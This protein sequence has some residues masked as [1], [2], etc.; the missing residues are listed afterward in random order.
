M[1]LTRP[2]PEAASRSSDRF[3]IAPASKHVL[4]LGAKNDVDAYIRAQS[5]QKYIGTDGSQVLI[6]A[7]DIQFHANGNKLLSQYLEP[8]HTLPTPTA[9]VITN[10]ISGTI[11]SRQTIDQ[12]AQIR[13]HYPDIKIL[14]DGFPPKIH[15]PE[16]APG[17]SDY[18]ASYFAIPRYEKAEINNGHIP[19]TIHRGSNDYHLAEPIDRMCVNSR[20]KASDLRDLLGMDH[21]AQRGRT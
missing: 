11:Q 3:R 19:L 21:V 9:I 20:D 18:R 1:H 17:F 7:D 6:S 15:I 14:V 2:R 8:N 4:V 16:K 5:P 12:L 13:R 10:Q